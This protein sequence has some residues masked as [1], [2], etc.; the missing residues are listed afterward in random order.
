M[1]ELSLYRSIFSLPPGIKSE[2]F[3]IHPER[4]LAAS[5]I[6]H[7]LITQ[8]K[9]SLPLPHPS[10]VS[11]VHKDSSA[12]ARLFLAALLVPYIGENYTYSKNKTLPLVAAVIR[13]SLKLGTQNHYLDGIP[14]L[15]SAAPLI[16]SKREDHSMQ[17]L[18]RTKLGL[19]L[20]NKLIH[21]P[22]TGTHW[23]ISFLFS[24][25]VELEPL[26]NVSED[27][28]D[29]MVSASKKIRSC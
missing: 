2:A 14:V 3:S 28:L 4:A 19:L 18:D 11:V 20:R 7:A 26:Y 17:P 13:E 27:S 24:L 29:G 9:S 10:L 25:V 21:N 12:K 8:E 1:H 15:F 16:R 5:S 22:N 23:T 6:L